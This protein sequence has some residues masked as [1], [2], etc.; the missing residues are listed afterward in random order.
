MAGRSNAISFNSFIDNNSIMAEEK[1]KFVHLQENS[2]DVSK[3]NSILMLEARKRS[4]SYSPD[5]DRKRAQR[6]R[7]HENADVIRSTE[8]IK[9]K[10]IEEET[11][12]VANST[13]SRQKEGHG[14]LR[15]KAV[16]SRPLHSSKDKS[17]TDEDESVNLSLAEM[18]IS[19]KGGVSSSTSNKENSRLIRKL[20]LRRER[21]VDI[22]LVN[23]EVELKAL[24]SASETE[25]LRQRQAIY[26]QRYQ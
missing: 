26:N 8:L 12:D 5:I 21:P 15:K 13:S 18:K 9:E 11:S 4:N 19:E 7:F 2:Y 22:E 23:A 24:P 17:L 16:N 3:D 6:T 1:N 10:K 20:G 14:L 25:L